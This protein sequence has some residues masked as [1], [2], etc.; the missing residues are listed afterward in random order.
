M[1]SPLVQGGCYLV[2]FCALSPEGQAAWVQAGGSILAV[3]AAFAVPVLIYKGESKAREEAEKREARRREETERLVARD[4]AL[5]VYPVIQ[6]W[7]KLS[8]RQE[9]LEG[10]DAEYAIAFDEVTGNGY[11]RMQ[12][13]LVESGKL[14][15]LG[16]AAEPVQRCCF[17]VSQIMVINTS[18]QPGNK[19]PNDVDKAERRQ[20][21]LRN[22]KANF[23]QLKEK[24]DTNLE[25]ARKELL[26]IL[27]E[28]PETWACK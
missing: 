26:V 2:G 19:N 12:E 10:D 22:A 16:L 13:V 18:P 20:E 24:L 21:E 28:N 17:L 11:Q 25:R 8:A 5:I 14:H 7:A 6:E 27:G 3:I 4:I 1:S 15:L 23:A 9:G